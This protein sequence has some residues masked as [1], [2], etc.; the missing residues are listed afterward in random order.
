MFFYKQVEPTAAGYTRWANDS[1]IFRS[2]CLLTKRAKMCILCG[3]NAPDIFI[4]E[5]LQVRRRI[6]A[7]HGDNKTETY[8]FDLARGKNAADFVDAATALIESLELMSEN[9][10][11]FTMIPGLVVRRPY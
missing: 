9:V 3:E 2:F 11:D 6:T 4:N 10:R 8:L 1:K 5:M 7:L